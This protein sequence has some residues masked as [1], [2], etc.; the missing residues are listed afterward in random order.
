MSEA[1]GAGAST[2][3]ALACALAGASVIGWLRPRLATDFHRVRSMNE[4]YALPSPEQA[5]VLSLGYRSAFA[6]YLFANVRVSYGLHVQEGER[7]EYAGNYF[8]VIN[9]LDPTYRTPYLLADTVLTLQAKPARLRDYVEAREILTR[10]MAALPNDGEVWNTAGKYIAYLAPGHLGSAERDDEWREAGA[11]VLARACELVGNDDAMP[12]QCITAAYILNERGR[13]EA[14]IQ[15]LQRFVTI[16]QENSEARELALAALGKYGDLEREEKA[17]ERFERFRARRKTDLPFASIELELVLPP[18]FAPFACA[19]GTRADTADCA[20][21]WRRW[22][23]R[24][25]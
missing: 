18:P 17:R 14:T 23:A 8:D 5:I 21:T 11:R 4:V 19:G 3:I 15:I 16:N 25:E 24:A 20:T 7:F 12:L 22:S 10:G 2:A 6:D 9:A 1:R 13:R